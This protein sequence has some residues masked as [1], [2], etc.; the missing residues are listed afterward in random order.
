MQSLPLTCIPQECEQVVRQ[1]EPY[2]KA[3]VFAAEAREQLRRNVSSEP[4][5]GAQPYVS[6]RNAS[7]IESDPFGGLD[8]AENAERCLVERAPGVGPRLRG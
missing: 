4:Q 7:G 3:L 2:R 8:G 1:P 5:G 6:G